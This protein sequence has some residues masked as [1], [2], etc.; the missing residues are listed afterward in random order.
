MESDA[1]FGQTPEQVARNMFLAEKAFLEKALHP[2]G[3]KGDEHVPDFGFRL[4][5]LERILTGHLS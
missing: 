4:A 3:G 5:V 1:F 2:D